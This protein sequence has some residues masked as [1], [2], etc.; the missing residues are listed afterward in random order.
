V[1]RSEN[2]L[3]RVLQCKANFFCT[4]C[5]KYHPFVIGSTHHWMPQTFSFKKAL[6]RVW[7]FGLCIFVF[8]AFITSI[9][10]S[11]KN[12]LKTKPP[13][14]YEELEKNDLT[15]LFYTLHHLYPPSTQTHHP[16]TSPTISIILPTYNSMNYLPQTIQSVFDQTF[17]DFELIGV[18]DA[19]TD[20]TRIP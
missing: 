2:I 1:E 9:I 11:Y 10:L 5:I 12:Y 14:F 20:H 8:N 7:L 3:D 6:R 17:Q 15:S 19:S 13:F 4:F 18:N 16:H